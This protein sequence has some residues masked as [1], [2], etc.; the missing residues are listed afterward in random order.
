MQKK[1]FPMLP[2]DMLLERAARRN[3]SPSGLGLDFGQ[4]II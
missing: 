3:P 4:I 1:H 2:D